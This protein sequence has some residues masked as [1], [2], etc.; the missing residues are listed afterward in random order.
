[1]NLH[2]VFAHWKYTRKFHVAIIESLFRLYRYSSPDRDQP[3]FQS[4]LIERLK[5]SLQQCPYWSLGHER[6][7]ELA[8]NEKSLQLAYNSAR[9]VEILNENPFK[10]KLLLGKCYLAS[11][12]TEKAIQYLNEALNDSE[13]NN[14]IYEDLAAGYLALQ[15]F[16]EAYSVLSRVPER[17]RTPAVVSMLEY[18]AGKDGSLSSSNGKN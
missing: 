8:L 6:L 5:E 18:L 14:L 9:A 2:K 17:D 4:Q 3:H 7:S 11:G 12:D 13:G 10:A 1:M 16:K 15:R